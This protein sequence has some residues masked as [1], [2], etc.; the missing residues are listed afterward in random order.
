[1]EKL[2]QDLFK[3]ELSLDFEKSEDFIEQNFLKTEEE[4]EFEGLKYKLIEFCPKSKEVKEWIL[5]RKFYLFGGS[6]NV[7][8]SIGDLSE[9]EENKKE[10]IEDVREKYS[11]EWISDCQKM[12]GLLESNYEEVAIRT[13]EAIGLIE[14]FLKSMNK[15]SLASYYTS[16]LYGEHKAFIMKDLMEKGEDMEKI[17]AGKLNDTNEGLWIN[18]QLSPYT[19]Y[20]SMV[21]LR[22]NICQMEEWKTVF[23]ESYNKLQEQQNK[24]VH[25]ELNKLSYDKISESIIEEIE[26]GNEFFKRLFPMDMWRDLHALIYAK[27]GDIYRPIRVKFDNLLNQEFSNPIGDNRYAFSLMNKDKDFY[28]GSAGDGWSVPASDNKMSDI[29]DFAMVTGKEFHQDGVFKFMV[30]EHDNK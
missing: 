6:G 21:F 28:S 3:K 4:I 12:A 15:D 17:T 2:E 16:S 14:G 11:K 24:N 30:I 26:S 5:D 1:M 23:E 29:T 13:E 25:I 19:P 20:V 9:V 7:S 18:S 22:R 10:Y 27:H 8:R